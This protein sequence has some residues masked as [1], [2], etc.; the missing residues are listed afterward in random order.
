MAWGNAAKTSTESPE[1]TPSTI[2]D[3]LS[4]DVQYSYFLRHLQRNGLIPLINTL[5][6]VTLF[7]PVN[8]AFVDRQLAQNDDAENLKRYFA[9][10]RLRVA[11]LDT[12]DVVVDSLFEP[13]PAHR[14][15]LKISVN[16]E[17][18][19]YRINDFAEIVDFDGYAKHQHSFIQA[20]DHFIPLQPSICDVLMD[21]STDS[22]NGYAVSFVKQIFLLVFSPTFALGLPNCTE[23]LANTSTV[24]LPTDAYVEASLLD[25][26]RK[27]YTA[28]FHGLRNAALIPAKDAVREIRADAL[29]LL[30]N[31][32]LLETVGGVNGTNS[33]KRLKN[34]RGKR[35]LNV[36]LDGES[37]RLV[38][39][40]KVWSAANSTSLTAQDGMLHLF[41]LEADT[42]SQPSFFDALAVPV[43]E[44]IPRRALY[45]LHFSNFVKEVRFR[46]LGY[47][48]DG[49]TQNQT[50]LLNSSDRDDVEDDDLYAQGTVNANS[51]SNRQSMLY[52]FIS[53]SVD[54][55]KELTPHKP[56]YHRLLDSKLCLKKRIGACFK[57]KLSGTL[58]KDGIAVSFNDDILSES[59]PYR[60]AGDN[61]IYVGD[62]DLE[63]PGSFKHTLA[64]L[65]SDGVVRRH[66]N[67]I[68][69]D[70]ESCMTTFSYLNQFKMFLLDENHNGYT[71]FLPCGNTIWDQDESHSREQDFGSWKG[72]GLVLK[73]LESHPQVMK[74]VLKG[75]FVE[76]AIYSDF[77]L[78]DAQE[79]WKMAKTLRGDYVNV[80]ESYRSGEFNHLIKIND[81]MLSVPLNSDVLFNQGVVHITSKLFLPE[82]FHI[83]FM[84]LIRT[85]DQ[86][87]YESFSFVNLL[88][89]FP[90]LYNALGLDG[91][92]K[93]EYSLLIPSPDL[94]KNFNVTTS[95][96]RLWE[97]LELHLIPNTE[98]ETLIRCINFGN[99]NPMHR[100]HNTSFTVQTNRSNGVFNCFKNT[101][102]QKTY[103]RLQDSVSP[104]GYNADHQV[105][106]VSHGCT[107]ASN[108]SCVFLL[109][110]PLSLAWFDTPDNFLHIHIGWISVGIGIII[111]IILFGFVTTTLVVCLANTNSKKKP[112]PLSSE[113]IFAPTESTYMRVTSDEDLNSGYY[114][115]GYETDD[116]MFRSERDQ[117]LPARNAKK[118]GARTFGAITP[119]TPTAP[120][121]IKGKG[122]IQSLNRDRNLVNI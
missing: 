51:F 61:T 55:E 16:P 27:Y 121:T 6:N 112:S 118:K 2:V 28:L 116:D 76:D 50:I 52:R 47:L 75:L 3:F 97:F 12:R 15:P 98:V 46:K 95:Y 36:T 1:P 67:H 62:K 79:L 9:N 40:G 14:F 53:G 57:V 77:G 20:I 11:Y 87:S 25:L 96:D 103:L 117:L 35:S 69:I 41:D 114:D 5:Q 84:D 110:K 108:S 93:S 59:F 104:L 43:A 29:S 32:C 90:K 94:L 105:R 73:Y 91:E 109:D 26:Q 48:I 65:I 4:A 8:L 49:T 120:R 22:I 38:V 31:L 70:K 21:N 119:N 115:Y 68:A 78:E 66:W 106:I 92:S 88:E 99:W 45:A 63:T 33:Q 82:D 37:N 7:A 18:K 54:M 24:F 23:F 74:S 80:S 81:T 71:V 101:V 44:M 122:L 111:G 86:K 58:E 102:T 30:L 89:K 107:G 34:I 113:S 85:T 10:Q 60:A 13:K 72:L 42:G 17:K 39:N 19:D 100:K 56:S 83:S 64:E